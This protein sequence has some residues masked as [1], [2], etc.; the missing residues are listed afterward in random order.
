M[1]LETKRLWN[2]INDM[3]NRELLIFNLEYDLDLNNWYNSV[4]QTLI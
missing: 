3:D 1:K 4:N 2:R